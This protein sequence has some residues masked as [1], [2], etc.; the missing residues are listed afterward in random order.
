MK[1]KN[2]ISS[3]EKEKKL[4]QFYNL[5]NFPLFNSSHP[6]L[7]ARQIMKIDLSRFWSV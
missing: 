2:Q 6:K 1:K 5:K 3:N 7:K 4:H